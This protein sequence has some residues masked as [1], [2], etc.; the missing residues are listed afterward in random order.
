MILK[1]HLRGGGNGT[2]SF[3]IHVPV[4]TYDKNSK[5]YSAAITIDFNFFRTVRPNYAMAVHIYLKRLTLIE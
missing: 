3:I 5:Q 4:F 1:I 2:E